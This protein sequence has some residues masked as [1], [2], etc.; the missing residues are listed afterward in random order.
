[1]NWYSVDNFDFLVVRTIVCL[2]VHTLTVLFYGKNIRESPEMNKWMFFRNVG[3]VVASGS[4]AFA[5]SLLPI[6]L[7]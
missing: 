4:Q 1:M 6:T 7:Y 3:G 2:A 5:I